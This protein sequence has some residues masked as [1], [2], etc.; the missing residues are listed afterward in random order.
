MA[1]PVRERVDLL[2]Y[3]LAVATGL[4]NGLAYIFWIWTD[5][6]ARFF[7]KPSLWLGANYAAFVEIM[8]AHHTLLFYAGAFTTFVTFWLIV[9]RH[10]L[11]P[12]AVVAGMLLGTADWALTAL[13]PAFIDQGAN[14]LTYGHAFVYAV[15]GGLVLTLWHRRLLRR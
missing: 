4:V 14:A 3:R 15:V 13:S 1:G 12:L 9:R 2:V 7:G 5:L 11:T 6:A 8:P 10:P